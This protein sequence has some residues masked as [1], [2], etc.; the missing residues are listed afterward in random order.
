MSYELIKKTVYEQIDEVISQ[1]EPE[2]LAEY[3]YVNYEDYLVSISIRI[4]ELYIKE[5]MKELEND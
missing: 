5:M 2:H 1:I 4:S 3:L